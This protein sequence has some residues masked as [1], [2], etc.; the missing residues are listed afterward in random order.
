MA[1]S[2]TVNG[3]QPWQTW[4]RVLDICQHD[5]DR[6]AALE[7]EIEHLTRAFESG[8]LLVPEKSS[9]N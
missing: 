1:W 7:D 4:A 3:L 2:E 8:E 6:V 9:E 5:E